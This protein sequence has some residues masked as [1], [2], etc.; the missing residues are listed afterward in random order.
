MFALARQ[1]IISSL[2]VELVELIV[3][4]T[5]ISLDGDVGAAAV[6]E[7]SCCSV[8]CGDSKV[9]DVL[10]IRVVVEACEVD[11]S[12]WLATARVVVTSSSDRAVEALIVVLLVVT[13]ETAVDV[14]GEVSV[15]NDVN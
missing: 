9:L 1:P 7:V 13:Y 5:R 14:A 10:V 6:V 12:F 8:E 11:E 3:L 4:L 15:A 2:V